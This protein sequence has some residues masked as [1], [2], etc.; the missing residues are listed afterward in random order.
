MTTLDATGDLR[1]LGAC[2]SS[3]ELARLV[4]ELDSPAVL[5]ALEQ[6]A[7]ALRRER[8]IAAE[9]R[10]LALALQV[11]NA[12]GRRE[13]AR[14]LEAQRDLALARAAG[15]DAV[16]LALRAARHR[17]AETTSSRVL[18]L[19]TACEVLLK[20]ARQADALPIAF[21]A[22]DEAMRQL[23]HEG[24][25]TVLSDGAEAVTGPRELWTLLL[26]VGRQ[27]SLG[28][29]ARPAAPFLARQSRDMYAAGRPAFAAIASAH[30]AAVLA[31]TG[32]AEAALVVLKGVADQLRAMREPERPDDPLPEFEQAMIAEALALAGTGRVAQAQRLLLQQQGER[33]RLVAADLLV[34][35]DEPQAALEILAG[36]D[37]SADPLPHAL[38]SLSWR[39]TGHADEAGAA[40]ARA[41]ELLAE[42]DRRADE[43]LTIEVLL[44][45]VALMERDAALK[46]VWDD[47]ERAHATAAAVDEARLLARADLVAGDLLAALGEP[48]AA[49]ERHAAARARMIR[50]PDPFEWAQQWSSERSFVGFG[51][52][53]ERARVQRGVGADALVRVACDAAAAGAADA[54][55]AFDEAIRC[56]RQ[57]GREPELL[58]AL[59]GKADQLTRSGDADGAIGCHHQA[60]DV[61]ESVRG[62]LREVDADP[63]YRALIEHAVGTQDAAEALRL[64]ERAK[65]R[66]LLEEIVGSGRSAVGTEAL[67]DLR[68]A[69]VDVVRALRRI[70][71]SEVGD[72][73]AAADVHRRESTLGSLYRRHLRNVRRAPQR[74]ATAEE[75]Q[76]L[77]T[78]G[79]VVLDYFCAEGAIVLTVAS[80]GRIAAA[81][82]LP[83]VTPEEVAF[84]LEDLAAECVQRVECLSLRR[85]YELLLEPAADVLGGGMR[86]L[87]VPHGVLHGVPFSA[88]QAQ[89]GRHLLEAALVVHAPSVAVARYA[90]RRLDAAAP[91]AGVGLSVA[92]LAY[93]PVERLDAALREVRELARLAPALT[94]I[95]EARRA[96]LLGLSEELDVLHIACHGEFSPG[97]P[98]LSRLYL[99]DGPVYAYDLLGL[100]TRPQTVVLS[101]CE[102]A[103]TQ[104]HAGDELFG[105]TRPFLA[106]G[107]AAVVAGLWK[108]AD[109]ATE[110]I[111]RALYASGLPAA[112]AV[113]AR[114]RAAQLELLRRPETAHP[115]YWA[116]WIVTGAIPTGDAG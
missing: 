96:D 86:I 51:A 73:Q 15:Q 48:A 41:S 104:R 33:V 80:N 9:Q 95:E 59:V 52:A 42:G 71:R 43:R 22:W 20:R 82:K 53:D 69:R 111:M 2:R 92:E 83:N 44:A 45:E 74:A 31:R 46:R 90:A 107:A 61:I 89:D 5:T 32:E 105:L 34:H 91:A 87:V 25:S 6:L 70:E 1:R 39:M 47:L 81:R 106:T 114:L 79:T 35:G 102:T 76:E 58:A 49:R 100:A 98:M 14:D 56:S 99:A 28:V 110:T 19:T 36:F 78:A 10:V 60:V 66:G 30:L 63:V 93:L 17:P 85:L 67:D 40:S 54:I 11:A 29:P 21:E 75:A 97:D 12:S 108:V 64:T 16:R 101:G 94:P 113:A 112:S 68:S 23:A 55:N 88:L 4:P 50:V 62:R 103:M 115:Y 3:A 72:P 116:P 7:D 77:A 8:M 109:A 13:R 27:L 26:G 38:S 65:S 57:A 24:L 37:A 18:T 84:L